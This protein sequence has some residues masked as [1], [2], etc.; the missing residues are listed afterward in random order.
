[1]RLTKVISDYNKNE[2]Y[3]ALKLVE[4][5][6][7]LTKAIMNNFTK[8]DGSL[9]DQNVIEE[10]G[11]VKQRLNVFIHTMKL[12]KQVDARIRYKEERIMKRIKEKSYNQV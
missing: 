12:Q 11:D 4:E 2:N 6:S 10:L 7:E 1:M 8:R 3:D 9:V 5:M